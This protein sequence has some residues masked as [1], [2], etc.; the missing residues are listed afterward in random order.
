MF[1]KQVFYGILQYKDF[2]KILTEK[3]FTS[4]P[5]STERKDEALFFIIGYLT[6]FRLDELPLDDFK[7]LIIVSYSFINN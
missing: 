3:L 6:I 2:L 4:K 1:I 7:Q 5:A